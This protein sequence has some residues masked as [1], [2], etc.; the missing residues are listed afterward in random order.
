MI[1]KILTDNKRCVC[2]FEAILDKSQST[3]SHHLRILEYAS[4][5]TSKKVGR[6]TYY[7][8]VKEQLDKYL[9]VLNEEFND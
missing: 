8:I 1:M 3:I 7:E 6:F 2:E 9:Y 4:L 5:I